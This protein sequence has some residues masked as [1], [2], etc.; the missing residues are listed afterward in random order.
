MNLLTSWV[1]ADLGSSNLLSNA[2]H[3][4][5]VVC[6]IIGAIIGAIVGGPGK[7]K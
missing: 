3:N 7:K 5:V 4:P 6:G 2:M 1:L